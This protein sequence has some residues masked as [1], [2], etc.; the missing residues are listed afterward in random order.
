MLATRQ[1]PYQPPQLV[2]RHRA[3]CIRGGRLHLAADLGQPSPIAIAAKL[4]VSAVVHSL[5]P[6]QGD[7]DPVAAGIRSRHHG[8]V[9]VH[10]ADH[11][12]I[13]YAPP[14]PWI[15]STSSESRGLGPVGSAAGWVAFGLVQSW[16]W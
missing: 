9:T 6:K 4:A 3:A 8:A 16:W 15:W 14:A 12:L 1:K 7:G 11:I 13:R 10:T 2:I 5:S